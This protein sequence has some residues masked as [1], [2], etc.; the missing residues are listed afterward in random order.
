VA[1][2]RKLGEEKHALMVVVV[3]ALPIWETG[4]SMRTC[5][6]I[7]RGN[8]VVLE[9]RPDLPDECPAMVQIRPLDQ[10]RDDEIAGAQLALLRKARRVGRLATRSENSSMN[11][12]VRLI[13]TNILVHAYTIAD[14]RKIPGITVINPFKAP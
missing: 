8:T 10:V 5:K 3:D 11:D 14:D 6:G 4:G 2:A 13:D 7:V 12:N 9:E 1:A